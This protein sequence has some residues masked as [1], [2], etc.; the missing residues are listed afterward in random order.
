[1]QANKRSKQA[2]KHSSTQARKH[3]S[4]LS[5]GFSRLG[6]LEMV[7]LATL[8]QCYSMLKIMMKMTMLFPLSNIVHN[9]V[10]INNVDLALFNILNFNFDIHNVVSTLI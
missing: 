9:N 3:A 7:M 1:M 6:F 8:F 10:Q 2:H 5:T 4:T